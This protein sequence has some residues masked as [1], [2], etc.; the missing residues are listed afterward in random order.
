MMSGIGK[1]L[2]IDDDESLQLSLRKALAQEGYT[3]ESALDGAAGIKKYSQTGPDIALVDLKMPGMDGMAVLEQLKSLDPD[4]VSIVITGHGSIESAVEAMKLGA[5]DFLPKP[6]SPDTLRI[7]VR[8]AMEHRR[9]I[10]ETEHLRM[11]KELMRNNFISM[12]S[13]ELRSPLSAVQQNLM[14]I[15][16]G[17]AGEI[18]EKAKTSLIRAQAR[19]SGLI[20]LIGDWL[21]LSRIETGE[22]V[23]PVTGVDLKTLLE[24][25]LDSLRPLAEKK[26]VTLAF[27]GPPGPPRA[28]GNA[29][30]LGMLFTNLVHNAIKF[31]RSGGKVEVH[32][33]AKSEEV[34]VEVEDDGP[35]IA[36]DKLPL[37]FE[38][39]YRIRGGD[40]VEGSGLGL[41]IAKKITELHSG[42]IEVESQPGAG[43]VFRV[44]LPIAPGRNQQG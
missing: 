25:T 33:Q 7:I 8:R 42:K 37:I 41:A 32:L 13:H 18:S 38:Q 14:T 17:Y 40:N 20:S 30:T 35:G 16:E 5:Y 23:G 27:S 29:Q 22:I 28:L 6:F 36:P 26:E 2:V 39:F 44:R 1:I 21:D 3:V 34:M 43:T 31:N 11:E 15:T 19:I 12:V 9:F 10:K 24:E 4:S